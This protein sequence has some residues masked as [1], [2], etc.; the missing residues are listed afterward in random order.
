MTAVCV[1][2][3]RIE[4]KRETLINFGGEELATLATKGYFGETAVFG[5]K[6]FADH[7]VETRY[8]TLNL[9]RK[10]LDEMFTEHPEIASAMIVPIA[11]EFE[12]ELRLY[13]VMIGSAI[14]AMGT[15]ADVRTRA[16]LVL[17]LTFRRNQQRRSRVRTIPRT[18]PHILRTQRYHSNLA[19]HNDILRHARPASTIP[20]PDAL[21][22]PSGT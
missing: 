14:W 3:Y 6:W 20:S 10:A 7:T 17:Q 9:S 11:A 5:M 18:I 12:R 19:R 16:A 13:N 1:A 8:N 22:N 4:P 21:P 2:I 15:M